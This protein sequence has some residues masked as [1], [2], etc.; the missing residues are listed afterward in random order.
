M[1]FSETSLVTARK[2]DFQAL[3]AAFESH[4]SIEEKRNL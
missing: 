4:D 2:K 1:C 3:F